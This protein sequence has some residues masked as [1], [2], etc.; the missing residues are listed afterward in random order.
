MNPTATV[1]PSLRDGKSWCNESSFGILKSESPVGLRRGLARICRPACR[2]SFRARSGLAPFVIFPSSRSAKAG[3]ASTHVARSLRLPDKLKTIAEVVRTIPDGSHIALGG[4][5]V[6]RNV[7]AV[8][9]KLIRQRKK[10]L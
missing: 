7:I 5:A 8:A 4:F 3:S 10:D 6:A 1:G 2:G 9:H